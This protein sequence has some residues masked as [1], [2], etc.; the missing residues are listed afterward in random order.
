MKNSIKIVGGVIVVFV[1]L[2]IVGSF[3]NKDKGGSNNPPPPVNPSS[4]P[5][6][7]SRS[8]YMGFTPFPPDWSAKAVDEV[9]AF[10]KDHSDLVAHHFDGGIPWQEALEDK[11]FPSA[12]KTEWN[13]RKSK[14]PSGDK[15]YIA[16]SPI[17][18]S[19]DALAPVWGSSENQ[20]LEEPW[21]SYR[22]NDPKVK[23]A[24]LNYAKRV[25]EYFNPDYLAIGIESNILISKA[26]EKWNDYKELHTYVYQELKKIYPKRTIFFTT[27]YEHLRGI[28]DESKK[29][30]SL[31]IPE[32]KKLMQYSDL[33]ALSTYRY[34]L[35]HNP[36][37]ETYFAEAKS[38]G[39]PIAI[40]EMGGISRDVTVFSYALKATEEDQ[41]KFVSFMLKK[42][43]EN[44]FPFVV[45]FVAIDYEKFAA[46]LP[47]ESQEVAKVWMYTGLQKSNGQTKPALGVWD[48]YRALPKK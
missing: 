45:N 35:N 47:K 2:A 37:T 9:Y 29:N 21:K 5:T 23:Q 7:S 11:E 30:L 38:L 12:L 6:I 24:F 46:K 40:A 44:K 14:T 25:V 28:D 33:A 26:P 48:A 13:T 8:F 27:Q 4:L 34:G 10:V 41:E 18:F 39:K 22:F 17:A 15:V 16:I 42:A 32:V 1:I 20:P 36:P 19:R 43:A 31:Q 3:V